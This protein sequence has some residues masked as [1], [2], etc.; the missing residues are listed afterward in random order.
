MLP[1][2]AFTTGWFGFSYVPKT[3]LD[4]V[5]SR[6]DA[7]IRAMESQKPRPSNVEGRAPKIQFK[8]RATRPDTE[9]DRGRKGG[10]E[11]RK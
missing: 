3:A 8:G 6:L 10:N 4:R 2:V 9:K 7:L 11:S 5:P 1:P